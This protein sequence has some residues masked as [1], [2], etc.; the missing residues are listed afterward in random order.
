MAP[1]PHLAPTSPG[2]PCGDKK[3]PAPSRFVGI[4]GRLPARGDSTFPATCRQ[5]TG[6]A[7]LQQRGQAP[8]QPCWLGRLDRNAQ[9]AF[10]GIPL[11]SV[12]DT[13][14]PKAT[15]RPASWQAVVQFR[16]NFPLRRCHHTEKL[17]TGSLPVTRDAGSFGH[18][19][20][21]K[22][23]LCPKMAEGR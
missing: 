16:R 20:L 15:V 6:G 5:V 2:K 7:F 22:E 13:S 3:S 18:L 11:Q 14:N 1:L 23:N 19:P 12:L 4:L 17:F 10:Q 21:T 9:G 8:D